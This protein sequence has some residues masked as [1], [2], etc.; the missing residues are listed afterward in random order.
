MAIPVGRLTRGEIL[1]SA[2]QRAGNMMLLATPQTGAPAIARVKLNRILESLYN[3][4]DWPFLWTQAPVTI[5]ATFGLPPDFLQSRDDWGLSYV[6]VDGIRHGVA[7]VDQYTF[8]TRGRN[9][10][11]VSAHPL[12][13][14]ADRVQGIGRT[15]P[16]PD[17]ALSATLHYKFLP[18]DLDPLDT[19]TYDAE[20]PLFPWSDFLIDAVYQWALDY[21]QDP[22][23]MGWAQLLGARLAAL[24]GT[25][26]PPRAKERTLPLDPQVFD[27]GPR[28][29]G[30]W[31]W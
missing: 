2:L 24:R 21:E 4:Y 12:M 28:R 27:T 20:I 3:E 22:R 10:R 11:A 18:A 8:D 17:T 19:V 1:R 6:S 14:T 7:E 25:A 23:A 15:Y 5:G 31:G 29:S 16:V 13:W 9:T 30:W 26:I